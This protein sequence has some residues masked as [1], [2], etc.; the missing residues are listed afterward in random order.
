MPQLSPLHLMGPAPP[1]R[2]CHQQRGVCRWCIAIATGD[3]V[4][5]TPCQGQGFNGWDVPRKSYL[6]TTYAMATTLVTSSRRI[7][8]WL[9]ST[10]TPGCSSEVLHKTQDFVLPLYSGCGTSADMLPTILPSPSPTLRTPSVF[11]FLFRPWPHATRTSAA[12]WDF[13]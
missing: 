10:V 2:A 4:P 7:L 12:S 1:H 3:R 11:T 8:S 9:D 6:S 13:M 5:A